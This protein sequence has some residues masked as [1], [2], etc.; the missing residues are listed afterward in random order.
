VR[1][2]F[3]LNDLRLSGGVGVVLEHGRRLQA[4]DD[5]DV[6]VAVLGQPDDHWAHYRLDGVEVR[7][8]EELGGEQFD[9]AIGT[10]WD[11]VYRLFELRAD[12]YVYF[13]QSLEDRFYE[14]GHPYRQAAAITYDLPVT[15]ITEARWIANLMAELRPD[16]RCMY[17]RNGIDKHAF[18][19][20]PAPQPRL[21]GP[22]RIV[23]EGY[24]DAWFKDVDGA[25]AA[26]AS[27][28]E[29]RHVTYVDSSGEAPA[30]IA[31]DRVV[32]PLSPAEMAAV[33]G[34]SDVLLKLSRVEGMFG[35]PLEAFHAGATC[36][37][38]PVT[39]HD[40]YI[41]HNWNALVVDWDDTRGCARALDL[42]A[43]DRRLLHFL[44]RNAYDTAKGWPDWG[45]ANEF[46]ALALRS[47]AREPVTAGTWSPRRMLGDVRA[48]VQRQSSEAH[49]MRV[50]NDA[51][52]REVEKLRG[53]VFYWQ[54]HFESVH[55]S[56][57]Y[58]AG[59]R[60]QNMYRHPVT[61]AV[62]RRLDRSRA[63]LRRLGS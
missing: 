11:T 48:A 23:I 4:R 16:A 46:M 35:P 62:R 21:D 26:A 34:E 24:H 53:D 13:L 30:S 25:C 12:H 20:L 31:A 61:V 43:R 19:S 5:F 2:C 45:Q 36:V 40:E 18:G 41:R 8:Y 14:K 58:N 51:L 37:V 27:M 60:L 42:L 7:A 28:S 56:R 54:H 17:V 47:I 52:R 59:L 55:Y 3:L 49:R 50:E 39:G 10:W 29:P 15:F 63:V 32:G 33:Y 9:L 38:T 22:L 6:T 1:I 44:R 57:A